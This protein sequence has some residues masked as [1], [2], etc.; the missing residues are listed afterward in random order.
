MNGTTP[1][2]FLLGLLLLAASPLASCTF[3]HHGYG[4]NIS[5]AERDR[6]LLGETTEE[7][8]ALVRYR[9]VR[10]GDEDV[11]IHRE[12]TRSVE[13]PFFGVK[14]RSVDASVA[15]DYALTPWRGVLVTSVTSGTAAEEAELKRGDV[16]VSM[17]GVELGSMEQ[18]LEVVGSFAP[19]A[20]VELVVSSPTGDGDG[21]ADRVIDFVVGSRLVEESE[22]TRVPLHTERVPL[23]RAGVDLAT[24]PE[25]L[26]RSI[27]G[28][29]GTRAMVA[30]IWTGGPAYKAGLRGGDVVE[31]VN[32]L[33]IHDAEEVTA[34]INGGVDRLDFVVSGP[35]GDH[36]ASVEVIKDVTRSSN[37]GIPILIDHSSRVGRSRTSVLDFIFQFGWNHR[38][39]SV[40]SATREPRSSTY[41]SILPFGM[42][43]FTRKPGYS[44]NR[45]FWFISWGGES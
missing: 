10:S 9:L 45:I 14:G 17:D 35:L 25:D 2:H 31:R 39:R 11:A 27:H 6:V 19:G 23:E 20:A 37:F 30:G 22:T 4:G 16:I 24:V 3:S 12:E 15:S 5:S 42:F 38:S 7:G 33:E 34:M 43:E 36:E 18:F 29:E 40:A 41:L 1:Q 8:G 32:G 26:M 44:R 21:R 13:L 28:V